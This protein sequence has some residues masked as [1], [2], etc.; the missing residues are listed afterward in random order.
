MALFSSDKE[1]EE[2]VEKK[3]FD[4]D[5]S[6]KILMEKYDLA[7]VDPRDL[8]E[9]KSMVKL[10]AKLGLDDED[11]IPGDKTSLLEEIDKQQKLQIEQNFLK[12]KQNDRI[13]K[14]LEQVFYLM[15]DKTNM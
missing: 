6:E 5:E 9:V 12:I 4:I 13:Y 11:N 7:E 3:G 1:K 8:S 2:R 14:M 15:E 10:A